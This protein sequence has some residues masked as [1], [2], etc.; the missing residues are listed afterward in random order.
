MDNE[1]GKRWWYSLRTP[2]VADDDGPTA[3]KDLLVTFLSREPA[4][5]ALVTVQ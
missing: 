3:G 2:T 4:E 5:R 1:E